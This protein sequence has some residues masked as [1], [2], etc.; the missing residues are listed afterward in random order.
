[1]GTSPYSHFKLTVGNVPPHL[2][3]LFITEHAESC[4][5]RLFAWGQTFATGLIHQTAGTVIFRKRHQP[6]MQSLHVGNYLRKPL[7][8]IQIT[9]IAPISAIP[10]ALHLVLLTPQP[11]SLQWYLINMIDLNA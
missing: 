8:G 6:P 2:K 4:V 7:C 3:C 1:M 5:R 11:D 9:Y 10:G